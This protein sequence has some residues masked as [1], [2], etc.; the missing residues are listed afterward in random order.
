MPSQSY[1]HS[2]F[3]AVR[4]PWSIRPLTT[5]GFHCVALLRGSVE[6]RRRQYR[7]SGLLAWS[8]MW[9]AKALDPPGRKDVSEN[10]LILWVTAAPV[11]NPVLQGAGLIR[12][13][14]GTARSLSRPH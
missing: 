2:T 3:T 5:Y 1:S 13:R 8:W 11:S 6:V 7:H 12:Q 14:K 4:P 10:L 9:R